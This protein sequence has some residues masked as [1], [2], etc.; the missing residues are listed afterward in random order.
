MLVNGSVQRRAE[1]VLAEV[2]VAR[3]LYALCPPPDGKAAG[4]AQLSTCA[5]HPSP[6][7]SKFSA[8]KH[9][10]VGQGV[11]HL[12]SQDR[13]WPRGGPRTPTPCSEVIFRIILHFDHSVGNSAVSSRVFCSCL[14]CSTLQHARV[15]S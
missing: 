4:D 11:S 9:G 1:E 2:T 5:H 15:T 7:G 14:C 8:C 13:I 10:I 3:A 12:Q 6:G